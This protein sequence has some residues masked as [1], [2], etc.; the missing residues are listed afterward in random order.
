MLMWESFKDVEFNN[1]DTATYFDDFNK[2][3]NNNYY[4]WSQ[5]WV[6]ELY[7]F[8]TNHIND[9]LK[10]DKFERDWSQTYPL[11]LNEHRY[12]LGEMAP[13]WKEFNADNIII[14]IEGNK[15]LGGG[16]TPGGGRKAVRYVKRIPSMSND[17]K[18]TFIVYG[19]LNV[20][21]QYHP[22]GQ[23]YFTNDSKNAIIGAFP[24]SHG[25][26]F[27]DFE[28]YDP[29]IVKKDVDTGWIDTRHI[30]AADDPGGPYIASTFHRTPK[31]R[32]E[33]AYAIVDL[34]LEGMGKTMYSKRILSHLDR[35]PTQFDTDVKEE[36]SN[37]SKRAK[38][39]LDKYM[40]PERKFCY[41]K[42]EDLPDVFRKP[43]NEAF[44]NDFDEVEDEVSNASYF[45]TFA[46][47]QTLEKNVKE[48]LLYFNI[49]EQFIDVDDCGRI[50]LGTPQKHVR[51][52]VMLKPGET[53][54]PFK[55]D[56]IYGDFD[57]SWC[58][59]TSMN[60]FPRFVDGE[61][62]CAFN[63]LSEI[64]YD[65]IPKCHKID[66]CFNR[67]NDPKTS[68]DVLLKAIDDKKLNDV[69]DY[70]SKDDKVR[71]INTLNT[72]LYGNKGLRK[73][74]YKWEDNKYSNNRDHN[75]GKYY[76]RMNIPE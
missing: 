1:N 31:N 44:G 68:I 15:M 71:D 69:G 67:L 6:D 33:I 38:E 10:V 40:K 66:F 19:S 72:Y 8:V 4:K 21:V 27:F 37:I 57:C 42:Q 14:R 39:Y 63:K 17:P 47:L 30:N 25:D 60:N 59:L 3:N 76:K 13:S 56:T 16:Y 43:V 73:Y 5:G 36:I 24:V 48:W 52:K 53:E 2:D 18:D 32:Q 11:K 29:D 49:G 35:C 54:L 22:N 58:G 55:I 65:K 12:F 70:Y 34:I 7:T 20:E 61:V 46:K 75:L 45:D 50:T 74:F 26:V 23:K 62:N 64:E 51:L 9:I 41:L 28:S